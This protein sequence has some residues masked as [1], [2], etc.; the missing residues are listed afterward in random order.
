MVRM[1]RNDGPIKSRRKPAL[2]YVVVWPHD[3]EFRISEFATS[4]FALP[5][6]IDG[7]P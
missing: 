1:Y 2:V 3:S 6:A 7:V 4:I 5:R